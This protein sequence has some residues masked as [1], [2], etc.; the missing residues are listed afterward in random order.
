MVC[1]TIV[2]QRSNVKIV[3]LANN[4]DGLQLNC[5]WNKFEDFLVSY[6]QKHMILH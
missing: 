5:E 2:A 4:A 6:I 1:C 3:N